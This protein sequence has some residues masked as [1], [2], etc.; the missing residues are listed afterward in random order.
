MN[1]NSFGVTL[2]ERVNSYL[3]VDDIRSMDV[4]P[5]TETGIMFVEPIMKKEGLIQVAIVTNHAD[6]ILTSHYDFRLYGGYQWFR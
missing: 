3:E 5:D 6:H 1:D 4:D 2:L